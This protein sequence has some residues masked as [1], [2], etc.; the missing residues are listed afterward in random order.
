MVVNS[1]CKGCTKRT[2]GCHGTCEGYKDFVVKNEELKET[3][4]L[5]NTAHPSRSAQVKVT[6]KALKDGKKGVCKDGS[7]KHRNNSGRTGKSS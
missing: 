3:K 6:A 5:Y 7:N 4:R 1:P 2:I